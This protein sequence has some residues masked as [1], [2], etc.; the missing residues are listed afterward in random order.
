MTDT[1]LKIL[2]SYRDFSRKQVDILISKSQALQILCLKHHAR[3]ACKLSSWI[4][5]LTKIPQKSDPCE[6][7]VAMYRVLTLAQQLTQL[8]TGQ[9]S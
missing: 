2:G 3:H 5:N 8:I 6:N 9:P 7:T 1:K 4:R